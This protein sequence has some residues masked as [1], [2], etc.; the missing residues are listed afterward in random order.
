VREEETAMRHIHRIGWTGLIVSV[1]ALA[2]GL[3]FVVGSA[4]A[5]GDWLL[6]PQ[7]WIGLGL[8]L[9]VIGLAGTALFGLVLDVVEPIGRW[10]WLAVPPALIV[11]G[12][13]ACGLIDHRRSRLRRRDGALHASRRARRAPDRHDRACAARRHWQLPIA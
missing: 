4:V 11:G 9:P 12:V 7:P 10:R 3:V 13:W 2:A 6:A 1:L 5:A 8:T